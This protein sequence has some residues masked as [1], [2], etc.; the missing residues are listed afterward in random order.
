[1]VTAT[2]AS[3]NTNKTS[4]T[5]T[6]D[7][8]SGALTSLGPVVAMQNGSAFVLTVNGSSFSNG[9]TVF[10]N[11]KAE[12]TT[13]VSAAQLTASV[14]SADLSLPGVLQ[15]AVQT[16][17]TVTTP[18]N[19]YVVPSISPQTVAVTGGDPLS[20][21]VNL[22]PMT[23][24]ATTLSLHFV[25]ICAGASCSASQAG[26]SFSLS[27]AIANGGE[28]EMYLIGPGLVPGTFF[29][30][31]GGSGDITVT[32]PVASDFI[33]GANPPA[34]RFNIAVSANTALGARSVAVMNPAG[35]ISVFPGGL[36]IT[37]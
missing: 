21:N 17:S 31:T 32:Q 20:V 19:F 13:F 7:T 33:A 16:G 30:F 29:I 9:N 23:I 4:V 25:G 2:S 22:S 6:I 15:V 1:M 12:T 26:T 8:T 34:V 18:Q 35:E 36:S 5:V 10:F 11:G 28:V 3:N 24:T 37:Q 14:S 27:Q